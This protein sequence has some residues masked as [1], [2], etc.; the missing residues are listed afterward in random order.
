MAKKKISVEWSHEASVQ[1]NDVL[2][3]LFNESENA[4]DIVGST[5]L[6][7][8]ARLNEHPTAHTLDCFKKPNDGNYRAF[9]V[10][11]YRISYYVGVNVI[12][13]LRVRHTSREPLDY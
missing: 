5:I 7:E 11:S 1:F 10:Y 4:A 9:I 6:D 3:Y 13:I 8:V 2:K 12:F